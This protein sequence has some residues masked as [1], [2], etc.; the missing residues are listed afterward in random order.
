MQISRRGGRMQFDC[1]S[2]KNGPKCKRLRE[3]MKGENNI[4]WYRQCK[5]SLA[6]SYCFNS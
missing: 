5:M 3:S 4:K 1:T 6:T 2:S